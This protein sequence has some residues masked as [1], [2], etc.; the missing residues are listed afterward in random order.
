VIG[1]SG[2]ESRVDGTYICESSVCFRWQGIKYHPHYPIVLVR[3]YPSARLGTRTKESN[4][5]ASILAQKPDCEA[6][7]K[8][9][10]RGPQKPASHLG[11]SQG[12]FKKSTHDGTRKVVN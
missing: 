4:M 2:M 12:M 8:T 9:C 11:I 6:K 10:V 5:Y 7:A 3:G 1:G